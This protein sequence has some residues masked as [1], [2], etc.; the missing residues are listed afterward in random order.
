ML[1]IAA[2]A[3][4]LRLIGRFVI[5]RKLGIDDWF[6][7]G[8]MVRTLRASVRDDPAYIPRS[9]LMA[10]SL[11]FAMGLT[12]TLDCMDQKIPWTRWSTSCK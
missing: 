10:T 8:G 6:M 3:V 4:A 12:T 7:I 11:R 9:S 2:L 1:T 5:T